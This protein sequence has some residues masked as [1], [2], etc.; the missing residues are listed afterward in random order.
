MASLLK[1]EGV[2]VR[3]SKGVVRNSKNK[4]S[5]EGNHAYAILDFDVPVDKVTLF[6]S[7]RE[8]EIYSDIRSVTYEP[9]KEERKHTIK[10]GKPLSGAIKGEKDGIFPLSI[11]NL[12]EH[13]RWICYEK[14]TTPYIP[15]ENENCTELNENPLFKERVPV[16]GLDKGPH[17]IYYWK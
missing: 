2:L 15:V 8:V 6:D 9:T 12:D 11:K 4:S 3:D 14:T 10:K 5:L 7:T 17:K 13:F 16:K 1:S